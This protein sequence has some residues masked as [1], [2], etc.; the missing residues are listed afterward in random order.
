MY[1]FPNSIQSPRITCVLLICLSILWFILALIP[2]RIVVLLAGLGQYGATYYAKFVYRYKA[3]KSDKPDEDEVDA[4]ASG[5]I[6]ENLFLSIPTDEDLRRTYFWEARRVGEREREKFANT[7]RQTRLQKLWKASWYGA[8]K[9]KE[10]RLDA[11]NPQSERTWNWE[12]AFV[13]IEGHRFIWW[14]SE[15]HFDTGE[16]PLGQ[17]FFAGHSGLVRYSW[18]YFGLFLIPLQILSSCNMH[19]RLV[20]RHW[21]SEN[22]Q[23]KRYHS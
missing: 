16:A 6:V 14:R 1:V 9:V 4:T 12:T 11:P 10:K 15:K 5:N 3:T 20:Y 2:T 19:Q 22:Y 23:K 18:V 17:I 21:I 7:K 13:L 8:V